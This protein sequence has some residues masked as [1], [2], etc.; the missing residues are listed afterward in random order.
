M[1]LILTFKHL[2]VILARVY[3][4]LHGNMASSGSLMLSEKFMQIILASSFFKF[5]Y[6]IIK[7]NT[8][9]FLYHKDACAG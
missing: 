4:F 9:V 1:V 2:Q 5:F 6:L 8:R 3:L 7:V